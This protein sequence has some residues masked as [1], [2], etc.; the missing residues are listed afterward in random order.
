MVQLDRRDLPGVGTKLALT[1]GEGSRVEVVVH[2]DGTREVF[3]FRRGEEEPFHS[4]RMDPAEAC[5]VG[6]VLCS[7]LASTETR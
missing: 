3:L 1:T 2:R 7:T 4:L 6:A 5:A